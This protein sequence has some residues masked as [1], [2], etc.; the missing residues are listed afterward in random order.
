[1]ALYDFGSESWPKVVPRVKQQSTK[2][3]QAADFDANTTIF[4]AKTTGFDVK[5]T[6]AK[7]IDFDAQTFEFDAKTIGFEANGTDVDVPVVI[8]IIYLMI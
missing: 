3:N 6:D 8:F 1:M 5:A 7:I 4:D 2:N